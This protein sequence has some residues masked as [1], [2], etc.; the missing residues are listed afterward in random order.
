MGKTKLVIGRAG[1]PLDVERTQEARTR[2]ALGRKR[3]N[4]I[5]NGGSTPKQIEQVAQAT[6][7]A[8]GR[9]GTATRKHWTRP[10]RRA[11]GKAQRLAR[12]R[13]R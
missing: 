6:Q 12:R 9:G 1:R 2:H 13:N 4:G 11:K 8:Q 5:F 10:E 3:L 7:I